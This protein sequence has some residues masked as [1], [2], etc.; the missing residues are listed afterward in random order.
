MTQPRLPPASPQSSSSLRGAG[1]SAGRRPPAAGSSL[2]L[3]G[4]LLLSS[5]WTPPQAAAAALL[6]LPGAGQQRSCWQEH[7]WVQG[8][9]KCLLLPCPVLPRDQGDVLCTAL[10]VSS[11]CPAPPAGAQGQPALPTAQPLPRRALSSLPRG[12]WISLPRGVQG[13]TFPS[14]LHRE[15]H[16]AM[17]LFGLEKPP[18]RIQPSWG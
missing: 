3:G 9:G 5:L 15:G 2:L 16:G 10:V 6:G 14:S 11:G 7:F 13:L 12:L 18:G 1:C 4:L 17:E 8:P